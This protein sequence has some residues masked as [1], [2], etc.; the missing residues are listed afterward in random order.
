[1]TRTATGPAAWPLRG[2]SLETLEEILL[3]AGGDLVEVGK[4]WLRAGVSLKRLARILDRL[5]GARRVTLAFA[6]TTDLA[7][8][9]GFPWA[10]Y[11]DYLAVQ[12]AQARFLGCSLFRVLLGRAS[13]GAAPA[14]LLDRLNALCADLAPIEA[15]V[16]LH[17]GRECEPEL[18]AAIVAQTPASLVV[19]VENALRAGLTAE[20]I[21][22]IVPPARVA[23]LHCRN[24]EG[25]W[26]EN[27]ETL[28]EERRWREILPHGRFLW[29][30]KSIDDPHRIRE[31]LP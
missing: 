27:P 2:C 24:L 20:R 9:D 26:V 3:A 8:C 25:R 12:R 23:Y 16:E 14:P 17:G 28:A 7:G 22:R 19:D 11:R 29:E 4:E 10:R 31:A 1:M 30:P 18:L 21:A 13:P 6:A 15:C 5:R